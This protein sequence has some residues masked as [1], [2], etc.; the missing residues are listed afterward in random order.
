MAA[1]D[2]DFNSEELKMLYAYAVER[3][4]PKGELMRILMDPVGKIEIP[5]D[6]DTK[7]QYL[8]DLGKMV[9]A[10]GRVDDDEIATMQKYAKLFDFKSENEEGIVAYILESVENNK[11]IYDVLKEIH[12]S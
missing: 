11:S 3:G 10:D 8:Y 7:I 12:N 2:G 4:V 9:L 5:Q 6:L 1:A